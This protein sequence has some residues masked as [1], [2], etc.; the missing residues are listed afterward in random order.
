MQPSNHVDTSIP[1]YT[2]FSNGE[3]HSAVA[4]TYVGGPT[5]G[6][7]EDYPEVTIDPSAAQPSAAADPEVDL[8]Q[9]DEVGQTEET[10]WEGQTSGKSFLVRFLVGQAFTIAW[11][12]LAIATWGFG[13]SNLTFLAYAFGS[14]L[15]VFWLFT[16]LK[17]FRTINS[18]NYRLTTRRLFVRT[19]LLRRRI[20]QIELLRVKDVSV[21][22]SLLGKWIAVGHVVVTSSEQRLPR[23]IL[24]G[25]TRP[26]HVMD[27]IWLQ[28]RA[29]LDNKTA[30][31]ESV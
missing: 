30:R 31:I 13:Y 25:I 22:Q 2:T 5:A 29:E 21:Q 14:V 19:G 18:H 1:P 6:D 26:R 15:L 3:V 28:T 7:T 8:N 4:P 10:L 17:V 11:V 9:T 16:G 27:L 23:A 20:D 24:Y 12:V